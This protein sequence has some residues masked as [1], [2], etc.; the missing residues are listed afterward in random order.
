MDPKISKY[1]SNFSGWNKKHLVM[2][3]TPLFGLEEKSSHVR[4][5]KRD[6]RTKERLKQLDHFIGDNL[7]AVVTQGCECSDG[8]NRF[9]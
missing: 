4:V 9:H 3:T 6:R 7:G 2:F 1:V 5:K 8:V